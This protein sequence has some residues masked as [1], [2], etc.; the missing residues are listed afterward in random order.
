MDFSP[1]QTIDIYIYVLYVTEI[2]NLYFAV[3]ECILT[4]QIVTI[5]S[6]YKLL[7]IEFY[8][9]NPDHNFHQIILKALDGELTQ[10]KCIISRKDRV[11]RIQRQV[12]YYLHIRTV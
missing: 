10:I 5:L 9:L 3:F 11:H 12:I 6:R 7:S 1:W 4:E 8:G 2:R